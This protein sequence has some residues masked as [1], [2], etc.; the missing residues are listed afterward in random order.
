[1]FKPGKPQ[2]VLAIILM[3]IKEV[4][5]ILV[6]R[7]HGID[8]R[9]VILGNVV[10]N[11]FFTQALDTAHLIFK[12]CNQK[13]LFW[14]CNEFFTLANNLAGGMLVHEKPFVN[15]CLF[16]VQIFSIIIG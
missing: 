7:D 15:L 1:M 14:S 13:I 11:L 3:C 10:L 4:N 16:K 12:G 2:I 9:I 6:A 8:N 5:Y